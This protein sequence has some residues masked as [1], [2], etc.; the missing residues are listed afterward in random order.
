MLPILGN[1]N[2]V[3]DVVVV[4]VGLKVEHMKFLRSVLEQGLLRLGLKLRMIRF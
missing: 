3:E 2:V 4:E 1:T